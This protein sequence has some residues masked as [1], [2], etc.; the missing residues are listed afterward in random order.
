[1]NRNEEAAA[2]MERAALLATAHLYKNSDLDVGM[3]WRNLE[4][5]QLGELGY[6]APADTMVSLLRLGG[7]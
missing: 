7:R 6:T 3:L 4:S 2:V 5:V 1:M